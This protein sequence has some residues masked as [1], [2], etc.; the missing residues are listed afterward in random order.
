MSRSVTR[1][2]VAEDSPLFVDAIRMCLA[3]DPGIVIVGSASDGREAVDMTMRLSPDVV[4][5][6]VQMP[7]L[8][9][10]A[11]IRE[12]MAR[13]PTPVL[14]LTGLPDARGGAIGIDALAAGA[15][16]LWPKPSSIPPSREEAAG[17]ARRVRL[18]AGVA[19][20]PRSDR[21]AVTSAV[22]TELTSTGSPVPPTRAAQPRAIGIVGSTGGPPVLESILRS[23]A[24]EQHA[25]IVIVQH[26]PL[27]FAHHLAGWLSRVSSLD[28]RVAVL[29]DRIEAG[30][31]HLAPDGAHL[32]LE[33]TGRFSLQS[34]P[35]VCESRPSGTV[36]LSSLARAFGT[37]AVGLVLTGLGRDGAEGLRAIA[38]AGGAAI[39]QDPPSAVA[40]SMPRAA[41]AEVP[42]AMRASIERL[43]HLLARLSEQRAP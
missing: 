41:L 26:L 14:V 31:V 22:A 16:D 12:I 2:L 24:A 11:A 9:G 33:A 34:G 17:L 25:P 38:R 8:D 27:G 1:V 32:E 36:L 28:V 10:I 30:S 39:V 43:P 13:R 3:T 15:V 23:L 20:V 21:R 37:G 5:M 4:T 19:V 35:P 7:V 40:P 42:T 29:G 6:D 18:V